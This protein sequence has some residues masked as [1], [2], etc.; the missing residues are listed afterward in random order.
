MLEIC[1]TLDGKTIYARWE[2]QG[3]EERALLRKY[4]GQSFEV[5]SNAAHTP[6]QHTLTTA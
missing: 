1:Y 3:D 4:A 2:E 5:R 6:Y